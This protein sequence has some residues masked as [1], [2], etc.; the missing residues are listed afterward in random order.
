MTQT[1]YFR[2]VSETEESKM[3]HLSVEGDFVWKRQ[4][5]RFSPT[6]YTFKLI[7]GLVDE[8]TI[9]SFT[10]GE[11]TATEVRILSPGPDC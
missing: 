4:T 5:R 11:V 8:L 7:H 9:A 10:R 1:L 2:P 6:T 3:K